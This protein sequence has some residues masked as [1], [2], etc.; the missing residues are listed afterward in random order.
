LLRG[1][2]YGEVLAN[3]SFRGLWLGQSLSYLG[4]SV[5]YVAVALYVYDL[6]GSARGISFAV[7]LELLPWVV[8]GP[9][10]GTLADYLDRKSMLIAAYL[11]QAG[12]VA[13]L[14]L[15]TTLGQLYVVVFLISLL[16]PVTQIVW[17]VALPAV[18][19]QKLFVRGSSLSIV[20]QNV[21]YVAG[22]ILGGWLTSI[23]GVR[24]TF[25]AVVACF[26]AA[27]GFSVQTRM[28]GATME[29]RE[30]F[31]LTGIWDDLAEALGFLVRH[32]VL[33]YLVLLN[34]IT[35]LGWSAPGVA[36]VVYVSETLGLGGGQYGLLQGTVSLGVALG[37]LVLGRYARVLRWQRLLVGGAVLAGLACMAVMGKPGLGLLLIL[38]FVSGVG[39]AAFWIIDEA[40]WARI[41]PDESRGRVYSLA[42]A[43][44][45]LV[46]AGMAL[47]GGWLVHLLGPVVALS[48][49]GAIVVAGAVALS[50]VSG[51]YKA[52]ARLESNGSG[53]QVVLARTDNF[54]REM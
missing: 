21:G 8:I 31:H 4:Q 17:A 54:R 40:I 43:I 48:I 6:T 41:T 12:L 51:G 50:T 15:T 18:A 19:G 1:D 42:D 24:P 47:L 37:V 11:I 20:A 32:P 49:I 23:V 3:R 14:T 28:P 10:T 53:E 27:A 16:A 38:W 30:P 35:S 9:L 5:I 46:D 36:A 34:C 29:R 26:L 7:A 33:R 25:W 44:I 52:I 13:L 45:F 22:P 39:W 2:S